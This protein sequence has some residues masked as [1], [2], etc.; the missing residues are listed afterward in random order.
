MTYTVSELN[1]IYDRLELYRSNLGT[2]FFYAKKYG[3]RSKDSI[4]KSVDKA[5]R[6]RMLLRRIID[7]NYNAYVGCSFNTCDITSTI[8]DVVY[9]GTRTQTVMGKFGDK[10]RVKVCDAIVMSEDETDTTCYYIYKDYDAFVD[11]CMCCNFDNL[12]KSI[13]SFIKY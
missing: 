1:T 2:L 7:Y 13:T 4:K 5:D 6:Y 8:M 12:I 9:N 11:S 10:I 3:F